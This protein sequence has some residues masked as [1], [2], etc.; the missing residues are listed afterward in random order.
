LPV[1]DEGRLVGLV[2]RRD[3]LRRHPRNDPTQA[4]SGPNR[5]AHTAA[6]P[7]GDRGLRGGVGRATALTRAH[8]RDH[9]GAGT[10][11]SPDST[12]STSS[13]VRTL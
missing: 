5:P 7:F 1:V 3:V 9:A 6:L 13:L 10:G 12:A 8:R 4:A 11:A 2:S